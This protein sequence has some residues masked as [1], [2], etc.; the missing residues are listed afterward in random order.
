MNYVLPLCFLALMGLSLYSTYDVSDTVAEDRPVLRLAFA[1]ATVTAF[2]LLL[3]IG[4]EAA[5]R[6]THPWDFS[7]LAG[8]TMTYLSRT[9]TAPAW[10]GGGVDITDPSPFW[11]VRE[12]PRKRNLAKI[13]YALG[14]LSGLV[15]LAGRLL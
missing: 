5:G 12:R 4:C 15:A 6:T 7:A 3:W 13:A 8:V 2:A 10:S 1:F 9:L 14:T 11:M